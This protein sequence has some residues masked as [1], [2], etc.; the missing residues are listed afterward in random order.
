MSGAE[1]TRGA[2]TEFLEE[3][4]SGYLV[5]L[6]GGEVPSEDQAVAAAVIR[7]RLRR[8]ENTLAAHRQT[9]VALETRLAAIVA[10]E[11]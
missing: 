3:L 1:L 10:V 7:E 8:L 4:A 11:S 9:I 5:R 2:S 6:E